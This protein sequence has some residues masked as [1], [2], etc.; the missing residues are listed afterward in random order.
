MAGAPYHPIMV[1][2]VR[3]APQEPST[4]SV[5]V[6][7][8]TMYVGGPGCADDLEAAIVGFLD[9]A[10]KSLDIAVQELESMLIL[11]PRRCCGPMA[12]G[13]ESVLRWRATISP[14]SRG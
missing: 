4:M 11:L 8:V 2:I 1:G 9:A 10:R 12:G 7:G 13:S 6:G 5:T 3:T 14:R